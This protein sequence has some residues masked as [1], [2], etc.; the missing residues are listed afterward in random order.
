[1][2]VLHSLLMTLREA[3]VS[4][5]PTLASW[6]D[7]VNKTTVDKAVKTLDRVLDEEPD[8]VTEW[9]ELATNAV[10]AC[11]V[12]KAIANDVL[13]T[14]MLQVGAPHLAA[15]LAV[16]GVI[17]ADGNFDQKATE[18]LLAKVT[19]PSKYL[20]VPQPIKDLTGESAAV[21]VMLALLAPQ[22]LV[23]W[24]PP[25]VEVAAVTYPPAGAVA[26]PD[27]GSPL[28]AWLGESKDWYAIGLPFRNGSA[29]SDPV[30]LDPVQLDRSQWS[31]WGL[32]A[33]RGHSRP[34]ADGLERIVEL[35]VSGTAEDLVFALG[36]RWDLSLSG[37]TTAGLSVNWRKDADGNWIHGFDGDIAKP[38]DADESP[39]E[40]FDVRLTRRGE[41]AVLGPRDGPH[42]QVNKFG[43]RATLVA[44]TASTE[45]RWQVAMVLDADAVLVPTWLKA[46]GAASVLGSELSL[47]ANDV[48]AQYDSRD[49]LTMTG[50]LGAG[51][52]VRVVWG[53]TFGTGPVRLHLEELR[54][55]LE[56]RVAFTG[57]Q[58]EINARLCLRLTADLTLGP[59]YLGVEAAGFWVG[60]WHEGGGSARYVGFLP[61]EGAALLVDLSVV[62]G[63][64][65]VRRR[66][67]KAPGA[68]P[69]TGQPRTLEHYEGALTLKVFEFGVKALGIY[70]ELPSG[71]TSA[72]L[73]LGVSFSPGVQLGYGFALV[74]VGGLVGINRRVDAD[75]VRARL[76]SGDA[77]GT[78]F[79]DDPVSDGPRVLA[80][81]AAMFPAADTRYVI[82]PMVRITWGAGLVQADL[83]VLLELPAPLK[84]VLLGSARIEV[85]S[86]AGVRLV[87]IRVDVLGVLDLGTKT[88]TFDAALI[89]SS[90]LERFS[91]SG[92]AA[93]RS[94][95]GARPYAVLSLG[96]FHPRYDP[97]PAVFP[98][99]QRM[100]VALS[101]GD[102]V[103]IS[104]GGYFAVSPTAVM[105]G[106]A[107]E[108]SLKLGALS[109]TGGLG[110]DAL[111]QYPPLYL[112]VE[113]YARIA[114]SWKEHRLANVDLR[115][116]LW[117]PPLRLHGRATIEV[118]WWD[119]TGDE[120]W[121]LTSAPAPDGP[122]RNVVGT[123]IE[124][125][126]ADDS[127][128]ADPD[129][130]CSPVP[131]LA[132]ASVT[133][134]KANRLVSPAAGVQWSQRR[135]PFNMTIERLDGVRIQKP[136][137]F[138]LSD[139]NSANPANPAARVVAVSLQWAGGFP[140]SAVSDDFAVTSFVEATESQRLNAAG[141][142]RQPAGL[143]RARCY[144]VGRKGVTAVVGVESS[145]RPKKA[146]TM[147]VASTAGP[148][149]V[150]R[151]EVTAGRRRGLP[152]TAGV[153]T[154]PPIT[155]TEAPWCVTPPLD[156]E[157][158]GAVDAVQAA[159]ATGGRAAP[160]TD[161]RS[162]ESD[163]RQGGPADAA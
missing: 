22:T 152:A 66:E 91:L 146:T 6:P 84:V 126:K 36:E 119:V 17:G 86:D 159:R 92:S 67:I 163:L 110:F 11:D 162:L 8:D 97:Q 93:F 59:V 56:T 129:P 19:T 128:V 21:F 98:G 88:L 114:V 99:M 118:L 101:A 18:A 154:E 127:I 102:D 83:A 95:W 29:R 120:T 5:D 113:I 10:A 121:E 44:P 39:V 40:R 33:V 81:L 64:G 90:L 28:P 115:G 124:A 38:Q 147:K 2:S 148:P 65:R 130:D 72:V 161:S 109:V 157:P 134:G 68:D 46:L 142:S 74:G 140:A 60:Y 133:D 54:A 43:L 153:S 20:A 30:Q 89:D 15:I 87:A 37:G 3:L 75:A 106:G 12:I 23:R 96:G 32:V 61:P 85:S 34:G 58:V 137:A 31:N 103:Q 62:T 158:L 138:V 7:A 155:L 156:V 125:L 4:R 132:P 49:G 145:Y 9:I 27:P 108:A 73:V 51:V 55:G 151:D 50:G 47:G 139:I 69:A 79:T 80:D 53:R 123:L 131:G 16:T 41:P 71:R 94:C 117:G 24:I 150:T 111:F 45:K 116:R 26:G 122:A 135:L 35:W 25:D 48:E 70:E 144:S 14:R 77:A 143:R 100:V 105:F 136:V 107:V 57:G 13:L 149:S 82:G 78:L 104:I 63:G 112:D 52:E 1:M 76:S 141:F 160:L 42:V